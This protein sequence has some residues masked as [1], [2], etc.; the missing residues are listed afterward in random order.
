M[1]DAELRLHG[2]IEEDH[3]W[4]VGKRLILRALFEPE[5]EQERVLVGV[6]RPEARLLRRANF[7]VIV[8]SVCIARKPGA[9]EP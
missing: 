8:S 3:W 1:N 9:P 7:P 4:F 6:Y 5:V 2:E